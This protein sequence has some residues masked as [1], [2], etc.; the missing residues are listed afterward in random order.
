MREKFQ[1]LGPPPPPITKKALKY[2]N[3][4]TLVSPPVGIFHFLGWLYESPIWKTCLKANYKYK[5]KQ[6]KYKFM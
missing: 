2:L 6:Y 3:N 5:Y 1:P 4:I